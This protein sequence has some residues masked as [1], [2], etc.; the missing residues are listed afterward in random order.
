M[1]AWLTIWHGL[2]IV[3]III[4]LLLLGFGALR[5]PF[6]QWRRQKLLELFQEQHAS[7]E[8]DFFN[9]A[10]ASGKPRGLIWKQ[11]DWEPDFRLAKDRRTDRYV[12]LYGVSIQFEAIPDGDMEGL[13]AVDLAKMATVV[14]AFEAGMWHATDKVVFNFH[15]DGML[16]EY[17]ARFEAI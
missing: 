16:Q 2:I 8:N 10:K 17:A 14:F 5:R 7:L 13:P 9:Q 3:F 4:L 6:A 1:L 11:I 15:P 12:V